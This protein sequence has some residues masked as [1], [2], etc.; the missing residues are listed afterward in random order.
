MTHDPH[1]GAQGR[2]DGYGTGNGDA[3]YGDAGYAEGAYGDPAYHEPGYGEA[4]HAGPAYDAAYG[5]AGYGDVAYGNADYPNPAHDRAGYG[6]AAYGHAAYGDAGHGDGTFGDATYATDAGYGGYGDRYT[7]T[8]DGRAPGQQGV[9]GHL[10]AP[11]P[12]SWGGEYDAD[13]TAFVQLPGPGSGLPGAEPLAAPGTGQGGYT[14][15]SL[16][17]FEP[18]A[19]AAG[20]PAHHPADGHGPA[21][22]P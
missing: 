22:A 6:H 11:E 7:G 21:A 14:P 9:Q 4:A 8:G 1:D 2:H 3:G 10:P 16:G 13:A 17:D 15:P 12:G 18:G 5:E 20:H 19:G